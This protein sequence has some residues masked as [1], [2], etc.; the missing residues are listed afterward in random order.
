M[1]SGHSLSI[2][3]R[4]SG[5]KNISRERCNHYY[6]Q[7]RYVDLFFPLQPFSKKTLRKIDPKSAPK[8]CVYIGSC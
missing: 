5:K 7:T 4:F 2:Y 3:V 6:I 1:P 8:Y